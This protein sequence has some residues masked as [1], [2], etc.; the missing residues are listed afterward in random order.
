LAVLADNYFTPIDSMTC[1]DF[2]LA[3]I[4]IPAPDTT[5]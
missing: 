5:K 1:A 2:W 3:T 4:L